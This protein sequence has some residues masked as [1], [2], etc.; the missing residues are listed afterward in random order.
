[1]GFHGPVR[2]YCLTTRLLQAMGGSQNEAYGTTR[3]VLA[4]VVSIQPQNR[5]R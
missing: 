4:G 1:M 5:S 3:F 2:V